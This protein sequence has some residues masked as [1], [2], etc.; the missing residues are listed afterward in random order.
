[1]FHLFRQNNPRCIHPRCIHSCIVSAL[2][3]V[4][5]PQSSPFVTFLKF[6]EC[7]VFCI[8]ATAIRSSLV[9]LSHLLVALEDASYFSSPQN[10]MWV[11]IRYIHILIIKITIDGSKID[12][13]LWQLSYVQL[14][15]EI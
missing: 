15:K 5:L 11:T 14:L 2:A 1:M 12:E 9:I 6:F 7:Y 10:F 8:S 13:E 3:L 4:M